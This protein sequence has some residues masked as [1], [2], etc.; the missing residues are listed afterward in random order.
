MRRR[1][2]LGAV[3][4]ALVVWAVSSTFSGGSPHAATTSTTST[5]TTTTTTTIVP[6]GASHYAVGTIALTLQE[7]VATGTP[8]R[9]LPTTVLFPAVGPSGAPVSGAAT[10]D[11]A[12]GPYP[13]VVFSEGFPISPNAYSQLLD[14]WA[15]AGYVVAAPTYPFTD[16]S[17]PGGLNESDIINHPADLHFVI[18]SLLQATAGSSG[19]LSGLIRANRIAVIGQS[20]GGDVS[21]AA[22]SNSCC[23]DPRISA[24][25]ILSGAELTSFGGTYF[26]GQPAVPLLV[27]QGTADTVNVP[28]CSVQIYDQAPQPK[29][30]L[31][32]LGQSHLSA[33]LY[34]GAP[35]DVVEKVTI[36]FLNAYLKGSS[37]SLGTMTSDAT[38][39]GLAGLSR[40][41]TVGPPL[42]PLGGTCEGAPT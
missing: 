14:A 13:L 33:Y 26:T 6:S 30:Y 9:T 2:L 18:S 8:A 32:L 41:P 39:A 15:S 37:A 4:V 17:A 27:V 38:V 11:R 24:A 34:A 20:D 36:D 5:T 31:S 22:V 23:R 40:A 7:P 29:Y 25:I 1:A 16:P 35:Q 28:A 3:L 12:S 21:L 19:A 10:P 42:A